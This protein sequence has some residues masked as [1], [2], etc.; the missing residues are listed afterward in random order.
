MQLVAQENKKVEASTADNMSVPSWFREGTGARSHMTMYTVCVTVR[1]AGAY[2]QPLVSVRFRG[3]KNS[4]ALELVMHELM[5]LP[6]HPRASSVKPTSM[7]SPQDI[8][9]E[10]AIVGRSIEARAAP[11]A[12]PE[13]RVKKELN[14]D[15]DA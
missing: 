3:Y 1:F 14:L 13:K 6:C 15:F 12:S 11:A 8:L 2:F 4:V 5:A 10:A 7:T 9:R